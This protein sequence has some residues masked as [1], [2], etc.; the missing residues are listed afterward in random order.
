MTMKT[1][2]DLRN[3]LCTTFVNLKDKKLD[4]KVAKEMNNTAGKIIATV[5]TQLDYAI[6][7]KT[8]PK[9]PYLK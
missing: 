7:T 9:I 4:P 8:K 5:K 6:I 3:E 2:T 1:I